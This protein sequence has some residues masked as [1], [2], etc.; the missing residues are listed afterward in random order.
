[1]TLEQVL[2]DLRTQKFWGV[3]SF[4]LKNGEGETI[5]KEET[6][7]VTTEKNHDGFTGRASFQDGR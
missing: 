6:I 5:R 3:V 1:M 4:T 2:Q 7:K